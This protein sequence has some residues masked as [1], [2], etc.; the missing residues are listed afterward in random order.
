VVGSET[1]SAT[2]GARVGLAG[3][4]VAAS[5]GSAAIV[6]SA[7][8]GAV[9]SLGRDAAATGVTNMPVGRLLVRRA[10]AIRSPTVSAIAETTA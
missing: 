2:G 9:V 4:S 8:G 10:V 6:G 3:G 1:F 7:W 5:G